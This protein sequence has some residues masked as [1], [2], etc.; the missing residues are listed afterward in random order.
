MFQELRHINFTSNICNKKIRYSFLT[1]GQNRKNN[2]KSYS[3]Q[4]KLP[5]DRTRFSEAMEYGQLDIGFECKQRDNRGCSK[6]YEIQKLTVLEWLSTRFDVAAAAQYGTH[7]KLQR[8]CTY[9]GSR[10]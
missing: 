8:Q 5:K 9:K 2:S 7:R 1:H 10:K 6:A 3:V 4:Y